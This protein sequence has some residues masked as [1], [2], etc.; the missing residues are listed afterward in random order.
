G[1]AIEAATSH[2]RARDAR[3]QAR[4]TQDGPGAT[5]SEEPEAGD[6]HC[7]ARSGGFQIR[8]T[9]RESAQSTPHQT[10]GTQRADRA[11]GPGRKGPRPTHARR[12]GRKPPDC[13][14]SRGP[15][16]Q[17]EKWTRAR[18]DRDLR[19]DLDEPATRDLKEVGC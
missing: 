15:D 8:R 6:R 5:Q 10:Q 11:S 13:E 1:Q 3:V 7:V 14:E 16:S 12:S 4:R 18:L 2:D 19:A 17:S 9:T